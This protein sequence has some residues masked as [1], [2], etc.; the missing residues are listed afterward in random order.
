MIL[1]KCTSNK[2]CDFDEMYK[3]LAKYVDEDVIDQKPR[4][5]HGAIIKSQTV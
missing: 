4:R 1:I 3:F 2:M 5:I